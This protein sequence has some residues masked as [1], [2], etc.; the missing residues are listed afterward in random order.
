M[1]DKIEILN[2]DTDKVKMFSMPL[3]NYPILTLNADTK[4]CGVN[5]EAEKLFNIGGHNNFYFFDLLQFQSEEEKCYHYKKVISESYYEIP[6]VWITS[7]S[8][9][10]IFPAKVK[11]CKIAKNCAFV[12]KTTCSRESHSGYSVCLVIDDISR[13]LSYQQQ[14]ME[15]L[16]LFGQI[17]EI[18][19]LPAFLKN[20]SGVFLKTNSAFENL[21]STSK[22]EIEGKSNKELFS[23][24]ACEVIESYDKKVIENKLEPVSYTID[25]MDTMITVNKVYLEREDIKGVLGVVFNHSKMETNAKKIIADTFKKTVSST[26]RTMQNAF[27]KIQNKEE[28]EKLTGTGKFKKTSLIQKMLF[29]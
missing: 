22:A 25:F 17:F 27:N 5:E 8:K 4:I 21:L 28:Q 15:Q 16:L 13:I 19:P 11:I 7:V 26:M 23:A 14:L 1:A 9:Y 29:T 12:D 3:F 6:Q 2:Q 20:E 10:R 18:L 24:E